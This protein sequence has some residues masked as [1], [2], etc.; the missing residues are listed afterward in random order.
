[1]RY[2][3][4]FHPLIMYGVLYR[5]FSKKILPFHLFDKSLPVTL[6]KWPQEQ[7]VAAPKSEKV[8]ILV[9]LIH[10]GWSGSLFKLGWC[11]ATSYFAIQSK[12]GT[13]MKFSSV[14]LLK[15]YLWNSHTA[16]QDHKFDR[17]NRSFSGEKISKFKIYMYQIKWIRHIG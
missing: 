16:S 9:N 15:F 12:S 1:M 8:D 11:N 14:K 6:V 2:Q 13:L 5:G 4:P 7:F 17:E 10:G 3:M